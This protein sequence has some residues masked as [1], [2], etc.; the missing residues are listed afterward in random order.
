MLKKCPC[1]RCS[2]QQENIKILYISIKL[3]CSVTQSCV[4]LCDPMDYSMLGF[5]ILYHLPE[6]AQTHVHWVGDAT[7]TSHPL[8]SLSPPA[9]KVYCLPGNSLFNHFLSIRAF[10]ELALFIRWPN[11]GASTAASVLPMNIQEWFPLGLTDLISLQFKGLSRDFFN[12][13]V[14]MHQLFG[15][16]PLYGPTLTSIHDY[17]KNKHTLTIQTF[18]LKVMSDF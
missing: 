3:P 17:W 13:A 15:T 1:Q 5:P 14:Q 12:T 18:V 2:I 11:I 9:F 8:S 7:Q 16:H 10:H 6:L 4:T